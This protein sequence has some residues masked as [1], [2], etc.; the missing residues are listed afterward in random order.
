MRSS[1]PSNALP[2]MVARFPATLSVALHIV[3]H[4][5]GYYKSIL[6]AYVISTLF[7]WTRALKIFIFI[8]SNASVF[9]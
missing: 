9:P 3:V 6:F 1:D 5:A 4:I 7:S 2:S 8:F